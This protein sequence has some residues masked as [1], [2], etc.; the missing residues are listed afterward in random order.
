MRITYF[1]ATLAAFGALT[2]DAQAGNSASVLQFGTTNTSFISQSGG[3]SN[4]ATTLQFGATN[5][6]TTL[7]SGSLLTVNNSVIGQGGTTVTA[8]NIA[9]AG[10]VGGSNSSLIGQ[11]GANNTAGVGQLGILNGSTILQQAP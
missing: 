2:A 10:Q 5:T 4:N 1:I 9:L 7:Q 8:S 3:T 6:A 11:I